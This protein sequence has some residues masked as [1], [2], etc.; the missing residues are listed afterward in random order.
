MG[1]AFVQAGAASHDVA[2]TLR[3]FTCD[4]ACAMSHVA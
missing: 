3:L 1:P 2:M 4:V